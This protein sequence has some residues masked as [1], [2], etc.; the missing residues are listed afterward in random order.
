ME[1]KKRVLV[2]AHGNSLRAL[3]LYFEKLTEAQIMK[4]NLPTGVPLV[5]EFAS[6]FTVT[7]KKYLG[8]LES[9]A[10]KMQKVAGQGKAKK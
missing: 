2:T 8:D 4:I 10:K 6:D 9:I 1:N 5:Y 3:I 7:G